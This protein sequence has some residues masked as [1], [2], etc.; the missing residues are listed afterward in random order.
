MGKGIEERR[1]DRGEVRFEAVA[2]IPR[3][4]A[5]RAG[6]SRHDRAYHTLIL[7]IRIARRGKGGRWVHES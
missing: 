1:W 4:C 7:A 6:G 5:C 3:A 2:G